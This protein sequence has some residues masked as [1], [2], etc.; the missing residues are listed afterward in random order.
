MAT[1][2]KKKGPRRPFSRRVRYILV[3][4]TAK[5]VPAGVL[6]RR[7]FADLPAFVPGDSEKGVFIS[8][9]RSST[10]DLLQAGLKL[11]RGFA[12]ATRHA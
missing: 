11:G 8:Y 10:D 2:T 1:K 3:G 5:K 6:V 9:G 7:R 4:S 12:W